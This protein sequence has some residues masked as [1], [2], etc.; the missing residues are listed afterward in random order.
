M[1]TALVE[2]EVE[3]TESELAVFRKQDAIVAELRAKYMPLTIAGINDRKGFDAVHDARMIVKKCRVDVEKTRTTLKAGLLDRGRKIDAEAKRV[4]GLLAPIEE[5]LEEQETAVVEERE[6]IKREA[7]EAR[8]AKIKS[9]YD[10]LQAAGYSGDLAAVPDMSDEYFSTLLSEAQDARAERDRVAAEERQRQ[11][12]EQA[13]LRQLEQE[14]AA[15]RA[16]AESEAAEQRRKE[17]EAMAAERE[18]LAEERRKQEAEAARLRAE[19]ERIAAEKAEHE[20]QVQLEAARQEAAERARK[21]TEERL[22]RE[23]EHAK[24][25]AAA[26]EARAK[27]EV[28]AKEAARV[29]A[30]QERPH[31]EKL[32]AVAD[33][34]GQITVPKGPRFNNV[35]EVIKS[36]AN[37]IREIANGSLT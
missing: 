11:E 13:R 22:A 35:V 31:R 24:A 32:L 17:Q 33:A 6:R 16:K 20:R 7:E 5:H 23:A 28:A 27:E 37:E 34:V 29:K 12:A 4:A 14:Q 1:S 30:E 8:K 2:R 3:P 9:R 10:L 18:R 25:L 21:E 15:A 26:N 19:Q 36:A